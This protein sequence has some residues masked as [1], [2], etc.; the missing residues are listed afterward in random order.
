[1]AGVCLLALG[2]NSQDP[3]R[4]YTVA[5]PEADRMLTAYILHGGKAWFFK[6]TGPE[7]AVAEQ[8]ANFRG[9]LESV[10]FGQGEETPTWNLPEGWQQRPGSA[11][12]F[13]TLVTAGEEPLET[14][15]IP[16][17][18]AAE[19]PDQYALANLNRW[20]GQLQLRPVGPAKLAEEMERFE[21]DGMPAAYANLLG[22]LSSGGPPFAN[23]PGGPMPGGPMP[24]GPMPGGPMVT[25]PAAQNDSDDAKQV[26]GPALPPSRS[27]VESPN[28]PARPIGPA[29]PPSQSPAGPAPPPKD[30][31]LTYD[32]PQ[33]WQ[34]GAATAFSRAAF[35]IGGADGGARV[36]VTSAS[37]DLLANVNRWRRQVGLGPINAQQ[38]DA[39]R[40][41]IEVDG[42]KADFFEIVGPES[43]I[44]GVIA[45]VK[46]ATW[47]I[48]LTGDPAVAERE[49]TKFKAFAE[50]L[51]FGR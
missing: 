18:Y 21:I 7:A 47:F 6:M 38:L 32:L 9:L 34:P 26:A 45:P 22:N 46:G 8:E 29:L 20:R 14:S 11:L 48:K 17:P 13:A 23:M 30:D 44:L 24:G 1:M 51:K 16:L 4:V 12:R 35:Q 28:V 37:G 42:A 3:I 15:V 49:K 27:P 25:P 2:C 41:K 31:G 10:R 36:T 5:K 39:S 19:D 40:E 43:A 50:S 33:G